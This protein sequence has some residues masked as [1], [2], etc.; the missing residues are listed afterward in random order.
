MIK[1]YIAIMDRYQELHD[2]IT[3]K[4]S[5]PVTHTSKNELR[6]IIV[7]MK[8]DI[9]QFSKGTHPSW[10]LKDVQSTINRLEE[11]A[12]DHGYFIYMG[13]AAELKKFLNDHGKQGE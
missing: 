5:I 4:H 8:I 7:N 2:S 3:E 12:K 13:A 9:Q 1:E 10:F 11:M 6:Y